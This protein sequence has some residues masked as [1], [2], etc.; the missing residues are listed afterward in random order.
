MENIVA[1]ML[2]DR[3]SMLSGRNPFDSPQRKM[4]R[5]R[6]C[7]LNIFFEMTLRH[8]MEPSHNL[9]KIVFRQWVNTVINVSYMNGGSDKHDSLAGGWK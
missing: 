2:Q 8:I 7:R 9:Q 6:H 1:S 5:L 4:V 3:K